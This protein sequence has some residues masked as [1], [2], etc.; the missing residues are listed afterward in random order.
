MT[1]PQRPAENL[2]TNARRKRRESCSTI[3]TIPAI[4]AD[5]IANN[6]L[7][8]DQERE[9]DEAIRRGCAAVHEL[10]KFNEDKQSPYTPREY[11]TAG[12]RGKFAGFRSVA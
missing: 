9:A 8:A 2:R 7:S 12:G 10:R 5:V 11:A 4:L 1:T 6:T 3:P